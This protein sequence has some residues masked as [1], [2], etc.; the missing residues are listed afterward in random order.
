MTTRIEGQCLIHP[1]YLHVCT[2]VVITPV[3]LLACQVTEEVPQEE[4]ELNLLRKGVGPVTQSDIEA[5]ALAEA[6]IFAF[7]TGD[8]PS[9]LKVRFVVI[10]STACSRLCTASR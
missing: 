1:S 9:D 10:T 7:N 8:T 4:V 2:S 3:I 6:P 5:A